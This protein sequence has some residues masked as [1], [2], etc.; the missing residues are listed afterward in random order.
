MMTKVPVLSKKRRQENLEGNNVR[1]SRLL[2][3]LKL[4]S[5]HIFR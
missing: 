2:F 3:D 1:K 4:R 5:K